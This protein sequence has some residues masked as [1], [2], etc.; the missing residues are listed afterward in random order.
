MTTS[1]SRQLVLSRRIGRDQVLGD[2]T[3]DDNDIEPASVKAAVFLVNAYLTKTTGAAQGAAGR[4]E[5][6]N[7]G[8]QLP[9]AEGLGRL[10][11]RRQQLSADTTP[12]CC[13]IQVDREFGDAAVTGPW[14][15]ATQIRPTEDGVRAIDGDEPWVS[16]LVGNALSQVLDMAQLGF[17]SRASLLDALV[18]DGG[19]TRC[20]RHRGRSD[21]EFFCHMVGSSNIM[22]KKRAQ[23]QAFGLRAEVG[24]HED[25]VHVPTLTPETNRAVAALA[26][27]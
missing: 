3:L 14:S 2:K 16:L 25:V 20:V 10:D 13:V 22:G 12:T 24:E 1:T 9:V 6:K 17:E 4:V 7:A 19:D 21:G 15:I 26:S 23:L 27:R 11:Q 18:V 8:D 5:S